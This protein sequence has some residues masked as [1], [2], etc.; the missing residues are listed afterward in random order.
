MTH[1]L[2]TIIYD[3]FTINDGIM[4]E[5]CEQRGC[6]TDQLTF[7]AFLSRW[8]AMTTQMAPFT[9]KDIIPALQTSATAAMKQCSGTFFPNNCGLRWQM[10]GTWDGSN[11]P[12]QQMAALEIL[13]STIIKEQS[14]PLTS[15]T[16][17]TSTSD[18]TADINKTTGASSLDTAVTPATYGD[19]VGAWFL[20][21]ILVLASVAGFYYLMSPSFE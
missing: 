19:K 15:S 18:P 9:A 8:M 12:G 4:T 1:L 5:V 13:L 17:G 14:A 2:S 3:F 21:V 6:D 20:T 11:G 16:G 10:N 7:K